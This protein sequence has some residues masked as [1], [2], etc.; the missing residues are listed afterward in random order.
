ML[1][2]KWPLWWS[3]SLCC[4][5][6]HQRT[7][8]LWLK[9]PCLHMHT[10]AYVLHADCFL[11]LSICG[12]CISITH[13]TPRYMI[14]MDLSVPSGLICRADIMSVHPVFQVWH[15]VYVHM[16]YIIVYCTFCMPMLL[17]ILSFKVLNLEF[18]MTSPDSCI[19][20][21]YTTLL[22]RNEATK[23]MQI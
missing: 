14:I 4:F 3:S 23:K 13:V 1:L 22:I 20:H 19:L 7:V 11:L 6:L 10:S 12:I 18:K 21:V 2:S 15:P 9:F 5:V 17:Y 16:H 8:V